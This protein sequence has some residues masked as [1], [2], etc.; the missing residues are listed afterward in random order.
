MIIITIMMMIIMMIIIII[1]MITI[2]MKIISARPVWA[3]PPPSALL[4]EHG[5]E[6]TRAEDASKT[7]SEAHWALEA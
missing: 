3:R 6:T 5:E 7:P 1:I 4:G 2:I